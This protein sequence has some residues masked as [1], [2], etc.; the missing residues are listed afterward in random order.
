M[1][2]PPV[3]YPCTPTIIS[4]GAPLVLLVIA[5]HGGRRQI[6]SIRDNRLLSNP[7]WKLI[8]VLLGWV[9]TREISLWPAVFLDMDL[10]ATLVTCYIWPVKWPSSR[11]TT[12]YTET[13]L[14]IN[15]IRSLVDRMFKD[16][17]ACLRKWRLVLK[18][19]FAGSRFPLIW[20]HN[21]AVFTC[22]L[23]YKRL[24]GYDIFLWNNINIT[25][26]KFLDKLRNLLVI[27]NIPHTEYEV[28]SILKYVS[29]VT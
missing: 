12:I 24:I 11:S 18:L 23:L 4:R 16:H 9:P 3:K 28:R 13:A 22:S 10:F 1:A 27:L 8:C 2:I 29:D 21:I 5:V 19:L 25:H 14:E 26:T 15:T 20:I 7:S 6:F 17:S